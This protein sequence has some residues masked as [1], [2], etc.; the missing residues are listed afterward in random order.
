MAPA[1]I[2]LKWMRHTKPSQVVAGQWPMCA[3]SSTRRT[4]RLLTQLYDN[5]LSEHGV[6]AVQYALMRMVESAADNG[7]AAMAKALGID[8]TTLS[9]N[10]KVLRAKG[11]VKS[12]RGDDARQRNIVLT[13]EGRERLAA[14]RPAWT[15][16]EEQFRAAMSEAQWRGM[17]STLQAISTAT[18]M[19][20][21]SRQRP[22]KD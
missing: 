22:G 12:V 1:R 19:A 3:L 14:A 13:T 10:L 20:M 9:R 11:W 17:W 21:E 7:Q 5:Y 2:R 8:K 4:A 18:E 15:R 6:E 16:A